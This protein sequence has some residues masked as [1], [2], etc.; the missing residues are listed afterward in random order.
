[1]IVAKLRLTHAIQ[2]Y[3]TY[4]KQYFEAFLKQTCCIYI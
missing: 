3:D 4:L 1:M 2:I